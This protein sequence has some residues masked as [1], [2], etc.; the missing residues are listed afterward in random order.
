M[1][2]DN[3]H[4]EV[5]PKEFKKV[6]MLISKLN[7][8]CMERKFKTVTRKSLQYYL[9][10]VKQKLYP[11]AGKVLLSLVENIEV[12]LQD[13]VYAIEN[14]PKRNS[15]KSFT[16][17]HKNRSKEIIYSL[18]TWLDNLNATTYLYWLQ[19]ISKTGAT[20]VYL[21]RT[22]VKALPEQ[23]K[24]DAEIQKPP[25]QELDEAREIVYQMDPKTD[26]V[27]EELTHATLQLSS[28]LA[29]DRN[30]LLGEGTFGVVYKGVYKYMAVAVKDVGMDADQENKFLQQQSSLRN[31]SGVVRI[32]GVDFAS[33][34]QCIV[35]ELAAGSLHDALHNHSLV[36]DLWLVSK[37]SI[38]EQV[39]ATMASI[40]SKGILHR[41]LKP[42][43]VLLF[44]QNNHVYAKISDFKHAQFAHEGCKKSVA[45]MAPELLYGME[46]IVLIFL[47]WGLCS[48]IAT[49][50]YKR[51]TMHFCFGCV[52]FRHNV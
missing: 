30:Q 48:K 12:I 13:A 40:S 9:R 31:L 6:D 1:L 41:D 25:L 14:F 4:M 26:S 10:D 52:L 33:S 27:N 19:K 8:H 38:L 46:K 5:I 35:M 51:R 18:Y 36:I 21:D 15:T 50:F 20:G 45:Y 28:S 49:F 32:F 11:L 2:G 3:Q 34:P 22:M 39:C 17:A 42:S 29:V 24:T 7:G 43:N 23:T 47:L 16:S 37:L 44:I